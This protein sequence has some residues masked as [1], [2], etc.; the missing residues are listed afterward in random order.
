VPTFSEII[1]P[2]LLLYALTDIFVLWQLK[3]YICLLE[4]EKTH[5][6]DHLETL[7]PAEKRGAIW[8]MSAADHYVEFTTALG[9]YMRRMTM[10][11][12]V[13]KATHGEGLRVHRSHWVAYKAMLSLEK[14]GER[15]ILT[16]RSGQRVPVSPKLAPEVQCRLDKDCPPAA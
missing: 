1:I 10:K 2:I 4:Y 5:H 8:L 12:A 7:L 3:P 9:S 6:T 16:L 14:D 13:E 11:S 15:F